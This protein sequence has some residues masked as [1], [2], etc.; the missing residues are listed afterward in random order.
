MLKTDLNTFLKFTDYM[1][2]HMKNCKTCKYYYPAWEG[3]KTSGP[4]PAWCFK[5]Q[6]ALTKN[7]EEKGCKDFERRLF[8]M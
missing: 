4:Q 7:T 3:S 1:I 6:V 2:D 8:G 5:K